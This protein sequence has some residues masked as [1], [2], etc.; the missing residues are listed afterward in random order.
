[1]QR[2]ESFDMAKHLHVLALGFGDEFDALAGRLLLLNFRAV[3]ARLC[4]DGVRALARGGEPIRTVL[5]S[6]PHRLGDLRFVADRL[7]DHAPTS[8]LRFIA[9]GRRPAPPD[10]EELRRAGVELCLWEPFDEGALRFVLNQAHNPAPSGTARKALRAPTRMLARVF[11]GTGQKAALVNNLSETGAFLETHHPTAERG[12]IRVELQL[13][14]GTVT[15]DARVVTT[16]VPGNLRNVSMPLGMGVE[17]ID[18]PEQ[19][20]RALA[21]HVE[22]LAANFRLD[23]PDPA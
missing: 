13:P 2:R 22:A 10:L 3:R 14:I 9:V 7:R 17:F 12:R 4:E 1:M 23:K 11:S 20:R 16:N 21:E 15:L 19:T 8:S 6:V 18:V 5:L